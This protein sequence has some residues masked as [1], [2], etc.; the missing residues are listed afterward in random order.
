[1]AASTLTTR[2]WV[3]LTVL[4]AAGTTMVGYAFLAFSGVV[5]P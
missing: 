5:V 1:V 3:E 4:V 2:R